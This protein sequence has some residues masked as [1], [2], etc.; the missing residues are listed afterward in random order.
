MR[1]VD[2]L[3]AFAAFEPGTVLAIHGTADALVPCH[4][5]AALASTHP[6]VN[7]QIEPDMDHGLFIVGDD[8]GITPRTHEL[9]ARL[10]REI[11][12]HLSAD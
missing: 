12:D 2:P 11:A 10:Y 5:T 3:T 4:T 1:L 6:G 7:V 8:D 9:Q